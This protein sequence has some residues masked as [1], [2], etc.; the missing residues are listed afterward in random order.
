[1]KVFLMYRD[2]DF[3]PGQQLPPNHEALIQDLELTTLFNAMAGGDAL[4]S[5]L[6]EP[7][8]IVYR[9]QVLA[10]CL[11]FPD[12]VGALYDLA[13]EAIQGEKKVYLS[14]LWSSPELI[15]RRSVQVLE[16]FVGVLKRL[17]QM[18]DEHA[19][20]F[21]SEG[22]T[23]FFAMIAEELDDA[24]LQTV[25]HHLKELAFRRGVLMSAELGVG[26]KGTHYVV[27]SQPEQGWLERLKGRPGFSFTI[28]DRDEGGFKALSELEGRGI[29]NVANALAQSCDHILSFFT[30]LRAELAFY[31]GC[32]N[33]RA[34]LAERGVPAGVPVPV[35]PGRPEFSARDLCDA[36]LALHLTGRVVGNDVDADGKSLVM[37]TG[38]NQGGKSTFLRSV[39]QAQLMM[40]CGMFVAAA[41]FKTDVRRGIFTHFKRE[42][43]ATM[44][45]GKLDEELSRMSEIADAIVPGAVVLCNESFASTN[46]R[47]GSEIARQVVRA[48]LDAGIKVFYVTHLYDLAHGFYRQDLDGALFLR[49]ERRPDGR[50]TYRLTVGEPLPTSYG[51]DSYRRIFGTAPDG[52]ATEE[53]PDNLQTLVEPAATAAS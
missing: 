11:A 26:N 17:R 20:Q 36:S 48:L 18:S 51:A 44:R 19:W 22:F 8:E 24:Y 2:R 47:E 23:R 53:A 35:A 27:R 37:I 50:R 38:A 12:I 14:L 21:R 10:D 33:L 49:P 45:H 52:A 30:M 7:A 6:G 5:S 32:L 43:D 42:E 3:D 9:Q 34:L 41:S 25:D 1:M 46:E 39:G 16:M 31:V 29:N 40:Q 28:P 13:V 4:L 15:L